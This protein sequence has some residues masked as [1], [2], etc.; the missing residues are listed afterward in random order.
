M[1][2]LFD[3]VKE[4]LDHRGL[5]YEKVE[6]SETI[7]I[8]FNGAT[9]GMRCRLAVEEDPGLVQFWAYLPLFVPPER[10]AAAAEFIA[11]AN[12][13]L[14]VGRFEMDCQDGELRYHSSAWP[15]DGPFVAQQTEPLIG[16]ALNTTDRYLPAMAKVIFANLDPDQAIFDAE[17]GGPSSAVA[18]D[19]EKLLE[20]GDSPIPPADESGQNERLD[21]ENPNCD[22][23]AA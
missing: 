12:F 14:R 6:G 19:L 23:D 5:R 17:F 9:A 21:E 7:H 11:R 20:G 1:G 16:S 3:A 8:A 10:R 15:G 4:H 18:E 22:T 13:G 2:R